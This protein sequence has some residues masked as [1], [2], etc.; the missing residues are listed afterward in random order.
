MVHTLVTGSACSTCH[1]KGK[2]WLG[3]PATVV[4]PALKASGSAHVAAG[5]CSTCHLNTTS[6]KGATDLPAN[7]IPLPAADNNNCALCHKTADYSVYTMNHVNITSNCIQCHGF[8]LSFANM[9]PPTLKAPPSG[10]TGHIP[11]NKPNGTSDIACELCHSPTVFTTF[12]GTV[13]RHAYVKAMACMSCHEIGMTWK[14]N[15][16]VRLWV[17][18]SANHHKGQDCDGSGCHS[19]RDKMSARRAVALGASQ[20][21]A[22]K[23]TLSAGTGGASLLG[24]GGSVNH[25][26][27]L[28][29][30]CVSCHSAASGTG[31]LAGHMAT[32]D[33]CQ[34]CHGTGTW[35]TVLRVDHTQ[36]LGSCTSCHDGRVARGKTTSHISSGTDCA[37]CHTTV[38]WTPAR[39]DH[40]GVA[41]HTC[42]TCHDALHAVGKPLNHVPTSAQCDTCHGTLGWKPALMDHT[43][44][45]ASC[46]TCHNNNVAL[47]VPVGHIGTQRD[48]ATCHSYPDWTA[49]RFAHASASYPGDHRAAPAC[50][51]CHTGNT[52]QIAWASPADAG[53]CGGCH[54]K[55]FNPARHP[56]VVGGA[57][58]TA[59][60]LHNCSG[61]CHVYSDA[62]KATVSKSLPG[63]YHRLGDL[64]FK[65]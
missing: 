12:A 19:S 16:G 36:V 60:E 14:T 51:A 64:A 58:Y 21:A 56:K 31:K 57:N 35:S 48:C 15:T 11:S 34:S 61:A 22:A 32:S 52:D 45:T 13:M 63:P 42:T 5:E 28:G 40:S 65:H 50:V 53:S 46:A 41:A 1:E 4:R 49:L 9:A 10:A 3:S 27:L 25:Q 37:S 59:S 6:F 54:A 43:T 33:S 44:L 7:H 62:T 26:R 18:D 24:G 23:P 8:G 47:G 30:A 29:T 39:F 55:D 20:K 38:A 17:R 2:A